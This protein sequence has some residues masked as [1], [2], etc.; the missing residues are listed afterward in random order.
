M[1]LKMKELE[2]AKR[3]YQDHNRRYVEQ[4]AMAQQNVAVL[5]RDIIHL[6]MLQSGNLMGLNSGNITVENIVQQLSNPALQVSEG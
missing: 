6:Q 1:W 2:A 3:W 4:M 5:D